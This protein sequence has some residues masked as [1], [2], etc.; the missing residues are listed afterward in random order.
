MLPR[1]RVQVPAELRRPIAPWPS[2]ETF[3]SC[4]SVRV[5][6]NSFS[7][8]SALEAVQVDDESVAH[9]ALQ[10]PLIRLVDLLDGNHLDVGGDS[11][12]RAMVEHLLGL[13][14]TAD[15]RALEA[16]AREDERERLD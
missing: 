5:F 8:D 9:V 13:G 12:L 6:M 10:H 15:E 11:V 16:A 4:P 14:D 1:R 3:K 2:A 7:F